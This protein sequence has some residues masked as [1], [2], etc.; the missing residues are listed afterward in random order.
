MEPPRLAFV[1]RELTYLT[2]GFCRLAFVWRELSYLTGGFWESCVRMWW[3]GEEWE[4]GTCGEQGACTAG[5][6]NKAEPAGL[7]L[8]VAGQGKEE[9]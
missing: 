8:S 5:Q 9:I 4:W 3:V 7:G 1:W 6:R 2:R